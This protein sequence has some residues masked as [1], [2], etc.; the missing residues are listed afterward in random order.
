MN[1]DIEV[2]EAYQRMGAHAE[3]QVFREVQRRENIVK[4]SCA[5][6]FLGNTITPISLPIITIK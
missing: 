6:Q 3:E 5:R 4:L 1:A 2:L